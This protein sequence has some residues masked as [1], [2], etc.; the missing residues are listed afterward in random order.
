M[1]SPALS[2]LARMTDL[3]TV[4]Q[5]GMIQALATLEPY[6]L[7]E[8]A[9]REDLDEDSH[10][11]MVRA[12]PTY[13]L[14]DIL[15]RLPPDLSLLETAVD[16][17]GATPDLVLLCG[18]RGWL[19]RAADLAMRID[20][21]AAE[22][23]ANRWAR[24][25]GDPLP[26]RIRSALVHAA[27]TETEPRPEIDGMSEWD[28]KEALER[29]RVEEEARESRAW[30]LLE[31]APDLW[32][33]LTRDSEHGIRV[34]RILLERAGALPDE[35]LL[36]C[37]PEITGDHLR[38]SK[39]ELFAGIRL[40]I[41]GERVRRW[42]RLRELIPDD[43]RRVVREAVDDG[44]TP[45]G[46]RYT[47]PNWKALAAVAELSDDHG[48]LTD[49]ANALNA[50]NPWT[51]SRAHQDLAE[52]WHDERADAAAALAANPSMSVEAMIAALDGLDEQALERIVSRAQSAVAD[53][54]HSRLAKLR[55]EAAARVPNIVQV[56]TDDDLVLL[57]D[58][59]G[60]LR[61]HLRYLRGRASQRDATREA[62]LRSRFATPDVLRALPAYL[63]LD[64]PDQAEQVAGMI[65]E[66][67][68]DHS[69]RWSSLPGLY[70][71]PPGKTL[72]FGAWLDRLTTAA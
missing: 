49:A 71:S 54:C 24:G 40:H 38:D 32:T 48:L 31:P 26:N 35:A 6:L 58:P 7:V 4:Q 50:D 25:V 10:A 17:H 72:T 63:V 1:K 5:R 47:G 59:A 11:C 13:L 66:S 57:P 15:D 61:N 33:D 30:R 41:A 42:P 34:Q 44:W 14:T 27:L 43:L 9:E 65:A 52:R 56:P 8:V 45:A 53:A 46:S 3:S 29:L 21:R 2:A 70:E 23:V 12:S 20:P 51:N 60:E 68:A 28:R 62:L 22:S 39:S 64:S 18:Q 19:D 37:L 36:A 55:R 69:E 67:C 16:A